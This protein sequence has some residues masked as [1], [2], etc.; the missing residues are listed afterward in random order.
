MERDSNECVI[1]SRLLSLIDKHV[2]GDK[3]VSYHGGL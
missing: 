3:L 2:H 1:K